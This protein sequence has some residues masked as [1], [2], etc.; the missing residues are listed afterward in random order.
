MFGFH[1]VSNTVANKQRAYMYSM[2]RPV[3]GPVPSYHP[4]HQCGT[5]GGQGYTPSRYPTSTLNQLF[6]P[7]DSQ[8]YPYLDHPNQQTSP[9]LNWPMQQTRDHTRNFV[10]GFKSLPIS[11]QQQ[12]VRVVIKL[13]IS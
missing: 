10:P 4:V 5:G 9:L 1:R 3:G 2:P 7:G 13:F 6:Q 11:M 12:L 8:R